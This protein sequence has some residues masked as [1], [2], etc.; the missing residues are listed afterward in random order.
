MAP[1]PSCQYVCLSG[2]PSPDVYILCFGMLV[3]MK[4]GFQIQIPHEK[5]FHLNNISVDLYST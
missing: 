4:P 2:N 3:E 1:A 5:I